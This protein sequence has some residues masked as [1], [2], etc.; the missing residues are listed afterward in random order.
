MPVLYV[1][2]LLL[3]ASISHAHSLLVRLY[4]ASRSSVPT[5]SHDSY[6]AS[7]YYSLYLSTSL[8]R[9]PNMNHLLHRGH[10]LLW[11]ESDSC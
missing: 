4:V 8:G 2:S 11:V 7:V 3:S 5:I 9:Y 1:Y 10:S 6:H